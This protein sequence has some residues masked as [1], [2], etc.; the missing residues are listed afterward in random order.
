MIKVRKG[1]VILQIEDDADNIQRYKAK[2]FCM[3]DQVTEEVI[4]EEK[5][6]DEASELRALVEQQK[7]QIEELQAKLAETPKRSKKKN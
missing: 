2:G 4:K 1:N 7:K 5:V 6:N 3:I